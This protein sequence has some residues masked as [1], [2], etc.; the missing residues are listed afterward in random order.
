[1]ESYYWDTQD[2]KIMSM[3]KIVTAAVTGKGMDGGVEGN[4]KV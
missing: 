1:L 4:L 2:G 3:V